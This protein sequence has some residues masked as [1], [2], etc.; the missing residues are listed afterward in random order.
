M[1]ALP[2]VDGVT[3]RYKTP[4]ALV[5]ATERTEIADALGRDAK[6]AEGLSIIDGALARSE[7][8]IQ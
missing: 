7:R 1:S 4:N 6:A 2:R 5:T 3:L 8:R